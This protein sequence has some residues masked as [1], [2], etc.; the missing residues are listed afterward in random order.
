MVKGLFTKVIIGVGVFL[1]VM[2]IVTA[3]WLLNLWPSM[4]MKIAGVA[5]GLTVLSLGMGYIFSAMSVTDA[6][7]TEL[8][9]EVI[10][11][12]LDSIERSIQATGGLPVPKGW[13]RAL[14]YDTSPSVPMPATSSASSQAQNQD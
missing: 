9:L 1:V 6:N 8:R 13:V 5:L 4:E 2:G 10:E 12:R 14:F 7:N 3:V 11:A